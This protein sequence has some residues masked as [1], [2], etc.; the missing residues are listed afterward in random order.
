MNEIENRRYKE[1]LDKE[2]NLRRAWNIHDAQLEVFDAGTD[3]MANLLKL[4]DN[5]E[6]ACADPTRTTAGETLSEQPS[7]RKQLVMLRN[8]LRQ[9]LADVEAGEKK[10]AADRPRDP[11][12]EEARA[13]AREKQ[14]LPLH[15]RGTIVLT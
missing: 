14:K 10:A 2:K 6:N 7:R 9:S 12:V 5:L 4:R 15:L 13:A 3:E 8:Q 11:V 1:T